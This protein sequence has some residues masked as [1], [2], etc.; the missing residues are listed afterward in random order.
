MFSVMTKILPCLSLLALMHV[1]SAALAQDMPVAEGV[2]GEV[3]YILN[4]LLFLF[5]GVLVM[6]MAAGFAML[7]AG[8]V[9]YQNVGAIV[10]KNISLYSLS[11][12]M[13]YLVGYNLMYSGVDGGYIGSFGI[14]GADDSAAEAGN[15]GE[16]GY[17]ASSDWFFQMV[18]VATASSIVSGAVAERMRVWAFLMF[19]A[20][21]SSIIYPITGSWKWGGGWLDG[22]GFQDFA[23]STLV[24]SVGGWA[25]LTAIAILGPRIGRFTESGQPVAILPSNIVFVCLGVFVLWLGWFGFNGGSQLALGSGADA[26]AVANIFVN[27]NIAAAAGVITVMVLTQVL[28]KKIDVYMALNGALAGLVSITAEPLTPSIGQAAIIGAV[29]GVIIMITVPLLERFR[30][31]DVV[32]AIPVHLCCG[33]WGTLIVPWTNAD[34]T[35]VAQLTGIVAIGGFTIVSTTVVW[36]VIKA[37]VGVRVE[38]EK[39]HE[40]LDIAELGVLGMPYAHKS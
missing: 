27:T 10:L 2:S 37:I 7:E 38:S 30:L 13:F 1:P 20:V 22:I 36:L 32:G 26:N 9:R 17:A 35:L 16:V 19:T 28:R 5:C 40:G 39:E 6:F 4:T 11:G 33:I 29:G 34:A 14:W 8:M 18:F 21:L 23:G 12:L 25:A 15:F 3:V 31:D 24:H